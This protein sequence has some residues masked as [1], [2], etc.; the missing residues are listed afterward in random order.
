M[1]LTL[2]CGDCCPDGATVALARRETGSKINALMIERAQPPG[3]PR[4]TST[5][6]ARD[7]YAL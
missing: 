5:T 2:P 7:A 3:A 1:A 4:V 6:H